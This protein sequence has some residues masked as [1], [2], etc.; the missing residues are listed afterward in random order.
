MGVSGFSKLFTTLDIAQYQGTC[1]DYTRTE[2]Y[3]YRVLAVFANVVPTTRL[4][5]GCLDS[6]IF[7]SILNNL[8]YESMHGVCLNNNQTK[9]T[10][11]KHTPQYAIWSILFFVAFDFCR[12]C[13]VIRFFHPHHNGQ[14]PPTSKDYLSQILSISFIFLYKFLRKSQYFPF[15]CSVLN[16]GTADT[17]L[18]T[19]LVWRGA[20]LGIDPGTSRTQSQHS[21]TRLSKRR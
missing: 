12:F 14:W 13:V 11:Y 9:Y 15:Y 7:G 5:I 20:W 8:K 10:Y 19:S 17:S 16:K 1:Q 6:H 4:N 2:I 3:T 18:I 21:I